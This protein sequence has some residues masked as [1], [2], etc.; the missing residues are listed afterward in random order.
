MPSDF[1]GVNASILFI[2]PGSS[3][4]L[5]D[6]GRPRHWRMPRALAA[7]RA[8]ADDSEPGGRLVVLCCPGTARGEQHRDSQ[9]R[10]PDQPAGDER[11]SV[12]PRPGLPSMSTTAMIG[13]GLR[14]TPTPSASTYGDRRRFRGDA[15]GGADLS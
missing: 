1:G 7:H 14:A 2:H 12:A 11:Q 4:A 6:R 15:L 8:R 9:H 5:S 3:A 10:Q 13:T